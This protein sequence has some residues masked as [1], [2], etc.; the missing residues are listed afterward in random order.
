MRL[1]NHSWI[2]GMLVIV[3]TT[4]IVVAPRGYAA[5]TEGRA[6]QRS[7]NVPIFVCHSTRECQIWLN[8]PEARCVQPPQEG[9]PRQCLLP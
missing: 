6:A 2:L 7:S 1:A 4:S 5:S 8:A 3:A 9:T